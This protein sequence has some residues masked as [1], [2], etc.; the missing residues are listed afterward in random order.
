MGMSFDKL[1]DRLSKYSLLV[2]E[3]NIEDL[4]LLENTLVKFFANVYVCTNGR[5]AKN[6]FDSESIDIILTDIH[7][8]AGC[9][10]EFIRH[11][12]SHDKQ[13]P[14]VVM[15]GENDIG[16]LRQLVTL[17]ISDYQLKPIEINELLFRFLHCID[18]YLDE[19]QCIL[20]L[21]GGSIFNTKT[22]VLSK[23]GSNI[24]LTKREVQLILCLAEDKSIKDMDFIKS[25]VW[26]D[27]DIASSTVRSFIKR[28]REKIGFEAVASDS[29]YGYS[30]K[31]EK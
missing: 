25:C 12:R 20:Y 10:V 3:D 24:T 28:L 26:E 18:K 14:I 19:E 29:N 21:S 4:K 16:I 5:D 6:I 11:I 9:G 27:K 8:P 7:M 13:I 30:L 1:V 2:A 31:F 15:T 22:K 23:N 17:N